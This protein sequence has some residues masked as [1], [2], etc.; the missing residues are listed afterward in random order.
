M[1]KNVE[2]AGQKQSNENNQD[3][4]GHENPFVFISHDLRFSQN[5]VCVNWIVWNP[6]L[7][8]AWG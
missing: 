6:A 3:A 7:V 4:C 8:V 2:V 1:A 5:L